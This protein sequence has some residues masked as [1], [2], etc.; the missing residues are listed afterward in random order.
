MAPQYDKKLKKMIKKQQ[1][2]LIWVIIICANIFSFVNAKESLTS[3]KVLESSNSKDWRNPKQENLIYM[4]LDKGTVIF[5]LAPT[6]APNTINNIHQLINAKYF[7]DSAFIRSQDNYVVQ[8]AN[9][10]PK[11]KASQLAKE[12]IEAEFFRS[13][14]GIKIASVNSQDAYADKV[15]FVDGFPVGYNSQHAWLTHCYGMLG[16]GRDTNPNSGNGAELYVVTGHSPRHLDKNVTLVGRVLWGME[17]LSTLPRGKGSMGFYQNPSEHTK[18]KSLRLG[19]QL[20]KEKQL[21]LE[22]LRTDTPVFQ[23]FVKAKTHRLESWF[24]DPTGKIELCNIQL[25]IREIKNSN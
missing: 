6:F 1:L 18:I 11:V 15:G 25:P 14:K 17:L 7:D 5:E 3:H 2:S 4:E 8:W 19:N 9:P 13:R 12:Q 21:Q 20:P 23:Q 22:V 24:V 16:V 10:K